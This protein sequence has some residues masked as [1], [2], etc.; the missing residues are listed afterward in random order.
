MAAATLIVP[1]ILCP[2]ACP[3]SGKASYSAKKA[4]VGPGCTDFFLATKAVLWPATS[5]ST[6]NPSSS[7]R[8]RSE[9]HTSELQSRFDLVCRLLLEKKKTLQK[10]LDINRA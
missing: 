9:E 2:Q 6:V 10:Y 3:S 1:I 7:R 8:F 4:I 5:F